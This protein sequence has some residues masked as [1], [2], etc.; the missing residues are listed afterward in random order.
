M[1][2]LLCIIISVILVLP[3]FSVI[4]E[5]DEISIII[6]GSKIAF[7]VGPVIRNNRVLVPMRGIFEALGC[8]VDYYEDEN[9][10]TVTASKGTKSISLEIGCSEMSVNYDKTVTLDSPAIIE[11]NRTLVPV[12]AISEALKA[13]VEWNA[14]TK[15]VLIEEYGDHRIKSAVLEKN[16]EKGGVILIH[17]RYEYPVIG[18]PDNNAF[19]SELN[20]QY[21]K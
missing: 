8:D 21:E 16:I 1:K 10:R 20:A 2:K 9:S 13:D 3:V 14:E 19:I 18:N 17:V 11:N 6:N 12:R 15:S 7:D 4:A 5:G